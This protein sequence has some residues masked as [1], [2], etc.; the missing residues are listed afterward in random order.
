MVDENY[1]ALF[2]HQIEMIVTDRLYILD[3]RFVPRLYTEGGQ[4]EGKKM[5]FHA[6]GALRIFSQGLGGGGDGSGWIY[7]C[8]KNH[9]CYMTN[10]HVIKIT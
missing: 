1:M 7:Y 2:N 10:R 3:P 5:P 4:D 9:L 6:I 8:P